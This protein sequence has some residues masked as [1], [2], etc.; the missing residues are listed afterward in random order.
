M[1]SIETNRTDAPANG[2]HA[3]ARYAKT[4][5]LPPIDVYENKDELLVIADI[6]GATSDNLNVQVDGKVLRFEAKGANGLAYV[7]PLGIPDGIDEA[8]IAAE[9]KNGLLVLRMPKLPEKKP[10]QI[11]VKSTG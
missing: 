8:A 1:S 7:R 2:T 11:P 5:E 4:K 3:D 10:R 9:T 6:P